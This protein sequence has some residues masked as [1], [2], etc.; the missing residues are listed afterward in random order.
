[1][2][3][4]A[5]EA[6]KKARKALIWSVRRL[7]REAGLSPAYISQI[8]SGK[9]PLT[10]RATGRIADALRIPAHDLLQ[11][12]GFIPEDRLQEAKEMADRAMHVPELVQRAFGA[13]DDQRRDW[14]VDD[15]L[16]LLG[17]DP[18]GG[19]NDFGPGAHIANWRLLD[20]ELPE[21]RILAQAQEWKRQNPRTPRPSAPIE[22][23]D[24]LPPT[25]Q[26]FIQQMVNKLRRRTTGE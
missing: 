11:L 18:S 8:E 22:G 20:P 10:P 13:S 16:L 23:W 21:S 7:A 24:E 15:Y 1:V 4:I 25:D 14:L 3:T 5:P 9:R 19:G 26:Q 6:I 12:A 17:E 2:E